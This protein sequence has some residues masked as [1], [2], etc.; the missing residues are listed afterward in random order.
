MPINKAFFI[1]RLQNRIFYKKTYKTNGEAVLVK[2]MRKYDASKNPKFNYPLQKETKKH[3]FLPILSQ[4]HTRLFPD[5]YLK[6]EIIKVNSQIEN[7]CGYAI[8]K[9]YV[10]NVKFI[11]A[12]PGDIVCVYRMG[13]AYKSF[14]SVVSGIGIVQEINYPTS[15]ED[16][17]NNCKNKSV[18]SEVELRN[19]YCNKEYRTIIKILFLE[20]FE[21]KVILKKLYENDIIEIGSGPR[22][23][24]YISDD[25]YKTILELGEGNL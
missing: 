2:N 4:Y 3:Y 21:H 14:T 6:N 13:E 19:F 22:I 17:L 16:Y 20:R 18:F 23:F 1:T 11:S 24:D 10:T 12:L 8:E 5:L 25:N 15:L 9:I 7:P